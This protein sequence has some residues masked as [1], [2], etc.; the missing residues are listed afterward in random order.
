MPVRGMDCPDDAPPMQKRW[1]GWEVQSTW[2]VETVEEASYKDVDLA[3]QLQSYGLDWLRRDCFYRDLLTPL[4]QED[5]SPILVTSENGSYL[6]LE[7]EVKGSEI[8]AAHIAM[9]T[10]AI[11]RESSE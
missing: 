8:R 11:A 10:N 1:W 6:R 5:T 9:V 3:N 4:Q 2:R 7:A